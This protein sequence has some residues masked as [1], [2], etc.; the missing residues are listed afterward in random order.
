M[1]EP[2]GMTI[3][4]LPLTPYD[5]LG[6]V[7]PGSMV[8][9]C[10]LVFEYCV[11]NLLLPTVPARA[12][13]D[14][15]VLT[16]V[17]ILY[18]AALKAETWV[19]LVILGLIVLGIAYVIG[20]VIAFLSSFFLDRTLVYKGYGYPYA[21]LLGF[22]RDRVRAD[23]YSGAFYRG[24]F[25]WLNVY[26]AARFILTFLYTF[27]GE[28]LHF[29]IKYLVFVSG[30]LVAISIPLKIVVSAIDS[31]L[32]KSGRAVDEDLSVANVRRCF[33]ERQLGNGM[34]I[35]SKR[36]FTTILSGLYDIIA[37]FLGGILNSR[38]SFDEH[39]VARYRMWFKLRFN[40]DPDRAQTNNFWYAYSYVVRY[41]G[42]LTARLTHWLTL[43]IFARNLSMAFYISFLYCFGWLWLSSKVLYSSDSRTA[44]EVLALPLGFLALAFAMLI[45][46]YYLFVCRFTKVVFRSFVFLNE[47]ALSDQA[48]KAQDE[49]PSLGRAL[50]PIVQAD[51]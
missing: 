49:V 24:I 19:P 50:N 8:L 36:F 17:T 39:F 35:I 34:L 20:H 40:A 42:V 22:S 41:S 46:F 1:E 29:P 47:V 14:T 23:S 7:T 3:T 33:A 2:E 16:I 31:A 13:I 37:K 30:W 26:L 5:I 28:G 27:A 6:Y 25:F 21:T 44:G 18:N 38:R 15:P 51:G 9:V 32:L 10:I 4:K 45:R 48:A 11:R 12:S 43:Y